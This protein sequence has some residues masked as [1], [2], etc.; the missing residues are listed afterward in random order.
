M[1]CQQMTLQKCVLNGVS[2]IVQEPS[3]RR[4]CG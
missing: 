3:E 4:G 1:L 2:M